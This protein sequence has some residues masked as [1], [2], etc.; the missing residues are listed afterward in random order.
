[1]LSHRNQ[2]YRTQENESS[3]QHT[4]NPMVKFPNIRKV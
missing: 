3:K 2:L 1:M 4:Q